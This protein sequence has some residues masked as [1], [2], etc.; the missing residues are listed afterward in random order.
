MRNT[1]KITIIPDA[2]GIGLELTEDAAERFPYKPRTPHTR[3]HIDGSVMD[4]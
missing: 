2:P 3:L 4:Q 1:M